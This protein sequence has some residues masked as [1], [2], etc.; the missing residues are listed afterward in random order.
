MFSENNSPGWASSSLVCCILKWHHA[1]WSDHCLCTMCIDVVPIRFL[2]RHT[3]IWFFIC[4]LFSARLWLCT[5]YIRKWFFNP[6]QHPECIVSRGGR[7]GEWGPLRWAVPAAHWRCIGYSPPHSRN[8]HIVF[9]IHR[10]DKLNILIYIFYEIYICVLHLYSKEDCGR[11][12]LYITLT[13]SAYQVIVECRLQ[14]Q[15]TGL[16]NWKKINWCG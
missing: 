14:T 4:S 10:C 16:G 12:I 9:R 8:I 13:H 11:C 6:V 5:L 3:K 1:A 7:E 2:H 15:S